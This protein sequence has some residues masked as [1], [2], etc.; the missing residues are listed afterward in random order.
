MRNHRF[1]RMKPPQTLHWRRVCLTWGSYPQSRHLNQVGLRYDRAR[2]LMVSTYRPGFY[3]SNEVAVR[4]APLI[5]IPNLLTERWD[6]DMLSGN[7][8]FWAKN[9]S[10]CYN[11]DTGLRAWFGRDL[12]RSL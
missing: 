8:V 3:L 7:S 10:K 11:I 1:T 12:S 5:Y 2:L 6:A 4:V 9:A